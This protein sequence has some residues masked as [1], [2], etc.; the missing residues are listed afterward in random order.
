MAQFVNK[1]QPGNNRDAKGP[2]A[3]L[4]EPENVRWAHINLTNYFIPT[5]IR[6]KKGTRRFR[7]AFYDMYRVTNEAAFKYFRENGEQLFEK[8]RFQT[9]DGKPGQPR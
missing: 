3:L 2:C 9:D 5:F 8:F 1:D 7:L 4:L 6:Y